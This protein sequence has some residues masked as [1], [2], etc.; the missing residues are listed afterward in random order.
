MPQEGKRKNAI[1]VIELNR[2]KQVYAAL[3]TSKQK[4]LVNTT[5]T[6]SFCVRSSGT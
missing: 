2:K 1:Y 5:I 3:I 4:R 6:N